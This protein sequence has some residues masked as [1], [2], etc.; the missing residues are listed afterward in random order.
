M[1][2][3]F[4]SIW[5][6]L[7]DIVGD[8]EAVVQQGIRHT[9]LEHEQRSARLA[10]FLS[11][12]GIGRD[13]KVA[14]YLFNS[15]EYL[16]THFAALKLRAVPVNVNYRYLD[17]ELAYLLE[18]SDSEAVVYHSSLG[19]QVAKVRDRLPLVKVWIEVRDDDQR[20]DGSHAYDQILATTTPAARINRS[21]MISRSFTPA[22]LLAFRKG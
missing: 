11:D 1:D 9:W 3:H 5:E 20:A 16:E 21:P 8:Q 18:N 17:T 14:M 19:A 2:T 22:A 15:P 12:A 7:A 4:A 10:G 6:S 13:S